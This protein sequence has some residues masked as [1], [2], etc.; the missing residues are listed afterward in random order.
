MYI[1]EQQALVLF[2]IAKSAMNF[3]NEGFAG[4]SKEEIMKLLNDIISQQNNKNDI[5]L[6]KNNK[7]LINKNNIKNN[8]DAFLD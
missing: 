8:N 4:Y 2:D 7:T 5:I 1:T 3:S 6:Q